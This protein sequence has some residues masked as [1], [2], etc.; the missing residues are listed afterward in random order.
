MPRHAAPHHPRTTP[1]RLVRR[2]AVGF[3]L[4]FLV[5]LIVTSGVFLGRNLRSRSS[6][7]AAVP[8][9]TQTSIAS[10]TSPAVSSPSGPGAAEPGTLTSDFEEL[11]VR[12]NSSVGLVIRTVGNQTELT[13]GDWQSGPAWS[14]IKVPLAI[15][16]LRNQGSGQVTDDMRAAIIESDN[17][18]AESIWA[19]LGDPETAAGEVEKVLQEAGD[20]TTVESQKIRPEFTAFGQTIWPLTEQARYLAFAACDNTSQPI[21]DLMGEVEANQSWGLGRIS[22]TKFKGGWGP[23]LSGSY[24]VRQIGLLKT[25]TGTA[26]VAVAAEPNSGAF[27]D[28]VNDLNE[29]ADWLKQH[30]A[31]LPAGTCGAAQ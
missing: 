14:T 29:V 15:A 28:G 4:L 25:P 9:P 17:A 30:L 11:K 19:S 26:S 6:I 16:A 7:S 23:S 10:P 13:L 12:L 2:I 27:D 20:Y 18:A 24:L 22:G 1:S 8:P 3:T 21:L 31:D 5:A